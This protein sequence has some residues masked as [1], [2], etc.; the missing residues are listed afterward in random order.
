MVVGG[1]KYVEGV[2]IDGKWGVELF[3][4]GEGVFD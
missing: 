1:C 4:G 2:I 3:V